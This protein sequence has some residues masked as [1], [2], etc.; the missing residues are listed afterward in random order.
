[1]QQIQICSDVTPNYGGSEDC[2]KLKK[3]NFQLFNE[4]DDFVIFEYPKND[5]GILKTLVSVEI[6]KCL[7]ER[8]TIPRRITEME[9]KEE[10]LK[11]DLRDSGDWEIAFL[12]G[13]FDM[14]TSII[15]LKGSLF[16]INKD[17]FK[18][19]WCSEILAYLR[20]NRHTIKQIKDGIIKN[21]K[22][23]GFEKTVTEK[24][25]L[26]GLLMLQEYGMVSH[27]KMDNTF[28]I[29]PRGYLYR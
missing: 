15:N 4:K 6:D 19:N 26:N 2:S 1:M 20:S 24:E 7:S 25:V 13:L 23:T 27:Y 17:K 3:Y 5:Y 10:T 8:V 12:V 21:W 28:D 18:D 9:Y 16:I 29:T 14:I 22:E 11:L